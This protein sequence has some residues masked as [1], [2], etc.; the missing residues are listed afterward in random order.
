M[1]AGNRKFTGNF[2]EHTLQ[3][4]EKFPEKDLET[5][6]FPEWGSRN[7]ETN[8]ISETALQKTMKF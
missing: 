8:K 1:R 3:K 5:E 4:S 6:K 2:P 7:P